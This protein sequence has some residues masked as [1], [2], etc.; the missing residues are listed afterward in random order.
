MVHRLSCELSDRI[1][2]IAPME[3][4]IKVSQCNAARAVPVME[5]GSLGD[6][7]SPF[8][9]GSGDTSVPYSV[10]VHL[11]VSNLPAYQS[12]TSTFVVQS[13]IVPGATD[14]VKQWLGGKDGSAVILHT[15]SS[16]L[17]H[18]WLNE[19]PPAFDWQEAN[20]TFFKQYAL[21]VV[22]TRHRAVRH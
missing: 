6:T 18:D 20:W 5:W 2:A 4:T 15:L 11:T 22:A 21:P 10:F 8:G 16:E 12:P 7:T 1:T 17:P 14:S 13:T 19:N 9:G 3:G